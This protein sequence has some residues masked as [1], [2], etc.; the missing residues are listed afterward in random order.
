MEN[1][2]KLITIVLG[3]RPEAIKLAPVIKIFKNCEKF[4]TRVVIT[5]QHK[6]MVHQVLRIFDIEPQK[7]LNIMQHKQSLTQIT[8]LILEG[9]K[10][11]FKEKKPS[12]VIVQGDTSTAFAAAL[13]A[14]YAQIPIGHIEA[15]LRTNQLNDPFPEEGNRRLI[16]QIGSLHFAPTNK[17]KL[18]LIN[19]GTEGIIEVT[20]NTVIDDIE[21]KCNS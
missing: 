21:A 19:S 18:N 10:K 1:N 16:S 6:E 12:L 15:G 3:T 8:C 5:G 4:K 13:G 9:L 20:G 7:D 11:D 14:F 17:S 2:K